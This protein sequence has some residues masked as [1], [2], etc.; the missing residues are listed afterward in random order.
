MGGAVKGVLIFR[1]ELDSAAAFTNSILFPLHVGVEPSKVGMTRGCVG[2]IAD[3]FF[4]VW[5][6]R[7]K[8]T[9]GRFDVATGESDAAL[10]IGSLG[11]AGWKEI[12][13]GRVRQDFFGCGIIPF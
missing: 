9:V 8:I 7:G 6:D 1:L 3:P 12:L 10:I 11:I 13:R 5:R 4:G 2:I